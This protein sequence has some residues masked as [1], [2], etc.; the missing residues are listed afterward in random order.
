MSYWCNEWESEYFSFMLFHSVLFKI[1]VLTSAFK[2]C[3]FCL[4]VQKN[5]DMYKLIFFFLSF[6]VNI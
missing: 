1:I 5:D 3:G 6:L 2:L 4:G